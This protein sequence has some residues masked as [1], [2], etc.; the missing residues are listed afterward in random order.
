MSGTNVWLKLLKS[1]HFDPSPFLLDKQ[2]EVWKLPYT[3]TLNHTV[4]E[5]HL[6]CLEADSINST[7][8]PFAEDI[9]KRLGLPNGFSIKDSTPERMTLDEFCSKAA[10]DNAF[11]FIGLHGGEGEN[12]TLQHKFEDYGLVFSGSDAKASRIGMDKCETGR[13][14]NAIGDPDIISLPKRQFNIQTITM[15]EMKQL[16]EEVT[17]DKTFDSIAVKPLSDGCSSGIVRLYKFNDFKQYVEIAKNIKNEIIPA[18]TFHKQ[19]NDINLPQDRN[20]LYFLEPFIQVDYIRVVKNDIVYKKHQGW[21][22]YTVGVVEKCG[23]YHAF[24]PSITIAE[25]EVLS[26]EEKFQGGTGVNIT[27]PPEDILPLEYRNKI[28]HN[29]EVVSRAMGIKSYSRIDIFFNHETAKMI[30]IEANSLPGMTPST[31]IYHQALA[32]NPPLT[33]IEFIEKIINDKLASVGC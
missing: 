8:E 20:P 26:L 7:L 17:A 31:V 29:I 28:K 2:G 24:N 22:E 33:P 9:Y 14:V 27:P 25:G 16:W 32:E 15:D 1:K 3:F 5:I 11:V 23:E 4:E 13:V 12:G 19:D 21:L 6:N 10:K 18:H 30:V